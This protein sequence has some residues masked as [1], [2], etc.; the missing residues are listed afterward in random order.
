[1]TLDKLFVFS[2]SHTSGDSATS[3]TGAESIKEGN[4]CEDLG[5]KFDSESGFKKRGERLLLVLLLKEKIGLDDLSSFSSLKLD[6]SPPFFP[7]TIFLA[8]L[9][10]P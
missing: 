4:T 7:E 9:G 10:T 2:I 8:D 6:I 3:L 5:S 1:M